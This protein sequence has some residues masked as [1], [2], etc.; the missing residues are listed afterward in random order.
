M[1]T[2]IWSRNSKQFGLGL[3]F[4]ACLG[5]ALPLLADPPAHAPAH[6]WRKKHDP[7][8]VGYTGHEW[9]QHYGVIEGRCNRDAVG[10]VLGG[11]VGGA[12]GS[13]VGDGSG[14][15]VAIV[16]G[17]VLGAVVGRE[18]GKDMD[19]RD[20]ACVGHSLELA[21][22]GQSVRW[23]NERTGV[24]YIV[25]PTTAFTSKGETCRA[26]KLKT[27]L[28]GRSRTSDTGAC[29]TGNGTWRFLS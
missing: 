12:I 9:P 2:I 28:D 18:I 7:Y 19:D 29:Q 15:A 21:K 13:Q 23:Q 27:S 22:S 16:L 3:A 26:F 17:T 6:G 5:L 10:A 25:T 20:R 8:Y 4:A 11:I 1:R 14:R 24:T